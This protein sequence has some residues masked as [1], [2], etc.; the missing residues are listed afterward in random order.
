MDQDSRPGLVH[1]SRSFARDG[2]VI[3]HEANLI[4]LGAFHPLTLENDPEIGDLAKV[5]DY[6]NIDFRGEMRRAG[7]L[8]R[9]VDR[10]RSVQD[11]YQ[12]CGCYRL[13]KSLDHDKC[14][15]TCRY[16]LDCCDAKGVGYL[17]DRPNVS[18]SR[19]VYGARPESDRHNLLNP[20]DR[21]QVCDIARQ[22]RFDTRFHNDLRILVSDAFKTSGLF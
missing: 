3:D 18:I 11:E 5:V 7:P 14:P 21:E 19:G 2:L 10:G 8:G 6:F 12:S 22:V 15:C 17:V 16:C 20:Y 1:W 4:R 9:L 13:R